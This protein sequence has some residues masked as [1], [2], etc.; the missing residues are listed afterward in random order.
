MSQVAKT[1]QNLKKCLCIKCPT[2]AMSCKL[3]SLPANI[4]GMLGD[5]SKKEHFEGMFCAFEKSGCIKEDR[6]CLCTNCPLYK[7]N[8]LGK[9]SYCLFSGGR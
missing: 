2:Y 4:A 5:L 8:N 1:K 3:K 9:I 6:S 7:E